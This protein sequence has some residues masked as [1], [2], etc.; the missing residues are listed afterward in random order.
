MAH[1]TN[2]KKLKGTPGGE[3]AGIAL[4]WDGVTERQ[5]GEYLAVAGPAPL[6]QSWSY[7]DAI[8]AGSLYRPTRGVFRRGREVVAVAQA[9]DWPLA[10]VAHIVK[11]VRG[12]VFLTEGLEPVE[13]MAV[14]RLLKDRW[15]MARLNWFF[16]T[17]EAADGAAARDRMAALGLKRTVTG[18]S[19]AWLDLS[20]G[21]EAVRAGLQQKWR[22]QLVRAEG[23][24]LRVRDAHGGP[25]LSW[26][27]ERHDEHRKRRRLRTS[28]GAFAAALTLL[29]PKPRDVLVLQAERGSDPL[30]AV[31]FLRHGAA[32]T[33]HIAWTGPEGRAA[34]AHNL[35]VW[36][37]IERL[38]ADGVRWL[39]LGGIDGSMPG[40]SR[41]KLGTGA[42]PVTLVG[43]WL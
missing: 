18:Y 37:G 5:W 13:R 2:A 19:T 16:F 21:V 29:A 30:A 1:R 32:A 40:V 43:T 25:S 14:F 7:G 10:G 20:E 42:E 12:P 28:T 3:R 27:L 17:P 38:A 22:N 41:F 15:P 39:D 31:L 36:R 24:K 33:Y 4:T 8:A 34:Y 23:E 35:L 26:L 6:E 11:L 9:I